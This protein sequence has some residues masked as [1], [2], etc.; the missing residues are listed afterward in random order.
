MIAA[1]ATLL[2]RAMRVLLLLA[3]V[4]AGFALLMWL[5]S[6][7]L[8]F[9][10]PAQRYART[11][12]IL[13]IPR[14]QGGV[15]AAVHL[16]NP[17]ARYTVLYSHG[18]GEDLAG[19]LPF[20]RGLRDAGFNVLAYD[21]S[22]YGL[23]TG[24]PSEQAAYD[25][26]DAA[27]GYLTHGAGV[28]PGRIIVHGRS[29]GGG[30]AAYLAAREPVAGLILESTFLSVR[31][32]FNRVP[33]L[34]F[35]RFRTVDRLKHVTAPVLVIHGTADEVIPFWHGQRLRA[36]APGSAR[37]FWVRGAG[38]NNLVDV[39]DDAYWRTLRDFAASLDTVR[40]R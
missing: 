12:E 17:A 30:P 21:Y 37:E 29:L 32:V 14:A 7:R 38:H 10:P 40:T 36:L 25:D 22:G 26:E 13:L 8:I 15:I 24:R 39:A 19:D 1:R 3:L 33:L 6:D 4:Y 11:P 27:Y 16:Q 18:N 35:D 2:R 31:A 9:M 5:V 34:P 23:S 20:L 28:P